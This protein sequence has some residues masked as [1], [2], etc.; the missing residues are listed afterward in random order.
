MNKRMQNIRFHGNLVMPDEERISVAVKIS[1]DKLD[2]TSLDIDLMI[3]SES[4]K[5]RGIHERVYNNRGKDILIENA[6]S[7]GETL[8]IS[9]IYGI[10]KNNGGIIKIFAQSVLCGIDNQTIPENCQCIMKAKFTPGGLLSKS[11]GRMLNPNGSIEINELKHE[12]SF[13]ETDTGKIYIN[14]ETEFFEDTIFNRSSL[15]STD[16]TAAYMEWKESGNL[17]L[18]TFHISISKRL[19]VICSVLSLAYRVPV[20][21]YEISYLYI[22]NNVQSDLALPSLQRFRL[23]ENQ[24]QMKS[25]PLLASSNLSGSKFHQIANAIVNSNISDAIRKAILYLS[26]SRTKYLEEAYFLCFMS[27]DFIADEILRVNN[28]DTAIPSG[29]WKRIE[30][31]L[32]EFIKQSEQNDLLKYRCDILDKIPEL[33]RYSFN[34]K[35]FQLISFLGVDTNG[36]WV[37]ISFE[38]GLMNATRIRNQLFHAGKV[39]SPGDMHEDLIRLQFLSERIIIKALNWHQDNIWKWNDIEL[40]NANQS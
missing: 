6:W 20:R 5:L 31:S 1:F 19:E 36:L 2:A 12:G 37:G 21:I 10:S 24:E 28:V 3:I 25:E 30:K 17:S 34:K 27:L 4:E 23:L 13:W 35:L 15:L 11:S 18:S 40:R 38:N 32:K 22:R 33:K 39:S 9:G 8:I 16:S 7:E 26:L 14:K 29:P